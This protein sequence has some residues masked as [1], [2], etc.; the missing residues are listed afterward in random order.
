MRKTGVISDVHGNFSALVEVVAFLRF[1]GCE[2]IVCLGDICGYYPLVNECIELLRREQVECIKGNHDAFIL[3]ESSCDRSKSAMDCIAYQK[4]VINQDNLGWIASLG[5]VVRFDECLG[6][7]GGLRDHLDEY[8]QDFDFKAA[9]RDHPGVKVFLTGHT[10]IQQIQH[11]HGLVYCNPGSVGQPRDHDPKAAC[12]II[13]KGGIALHRVEYP[14]ERTAAA[15]KAAG[16]SDYYYGNLYH[17][18]RIGE[19]R[20]LDER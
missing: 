14:I 5:E 16:F 12:A 9:T 3:G 18:C 10:H 4:K 13:D 11:A 6:V 15:M 20:G 7:H 19:R 1:E 17:G 8:V 2:R